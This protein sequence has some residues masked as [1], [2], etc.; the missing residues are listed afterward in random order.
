MGEAISLAA[1]QLVLHDPGRKKEDPGKSRSAASTVP[2]SA[3]MPLTP[4]TPG[5]TSLA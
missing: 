1:N 4:P 5:G 3:C 2:R